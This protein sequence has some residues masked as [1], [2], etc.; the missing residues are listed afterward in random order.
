MASRNLMRQR[1]GA[2]Q[3]RVLHLFSLTNRNREAE[4]AYVRLYILL[5]R[6]VYGFATV[7]H[8]FS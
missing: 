1:G 6:I 7:M 5:V 4:V 8:L 3:T 2:A